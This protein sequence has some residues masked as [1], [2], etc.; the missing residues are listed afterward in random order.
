MRS[1]EIIEEAV[2]Y[3]RKLF[4]G[5]SDGHGPDH[6]LRVYRT[7]MCLA[8]SEPACDR[9]VVA[10]A[11]LLHDADDD[12]L[13]RTE[14]NGNA[15]A[16]LESRQVDPETADRICDTVNAVSFRKNRDRQPETPEAKI[17]QDAD[18]LD[19]LGAVGI[20]RTFAYGGC[21]GRDPEASIGHFHEKLLLLR[22]R[23][24]TPAARR[25]ADDRHRF[26]EAFL[27]EWRRETE[28][29]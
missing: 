23:M 29:E 16:F 7:A 12:K 2:R 4:E 27:E 9:F 13:F 8:D 1:E 24:N 14:N 22:D 10:L 28:G 19:A 18:R 15:R 21:H 11:A 26:M 25:L 3:V 6:T 17:V 20:A 5:N